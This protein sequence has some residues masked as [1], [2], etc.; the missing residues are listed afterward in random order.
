MSDKKVFK[1]GFLTNADLIEVYA[2]NYIEI[3]LYASVV[4]LHGNLPDF[5]FFHI[6]Y[7]T[8]MYDIPD[9]LQIS[10]VIKQLY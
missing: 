2:Q 3:V 5:G 8:T 4:D 6:D 10:V 9:V 7:A 1:I